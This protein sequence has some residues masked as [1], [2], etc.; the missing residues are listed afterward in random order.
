MHAILLETTYDE[1]LTHL[2]DVFRNESPDVLHLRGTRMGIDEVRTLI[3]E[4]FLTPM[5]ASERVFILAYPSYTHEAQNAL[6]KLL[7]EPPRTARFY[8]ITERAGVLLPTLR[9]RFMVEDVQRAEQHFTIDTFLRLS[10]GERLAEI[11]RRIE[12]KDDVWVSELIKALE[13]WAHES[14]DAA[15]MKSFFDLAPSF[16]TPGASKKMILEHLA[17][18]LP[19]H[20]SA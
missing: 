7:E 20:T 11:A 3:R 16:H 18:L 19:S 9:S 10:Y 12:K 5:N 6:L 14:H 1:A 17:L 2:P 8:M 13:R 15:F 4:A